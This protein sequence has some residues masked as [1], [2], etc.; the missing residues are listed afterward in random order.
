ADL[1]QFQLPSVLV[2]RT[3][4]LR[5]SPAESRPPSVYRLVRSGAYYDVWQR[6]EHFAPI[7][8]HLPLGSD[9]QPGAVPSCSQV[10]ALAR[11][12]PRG[13]L[14][15]VPRSRVVLP[16]W[17]RARYAGSWPTGAGSAEA[18][19]TTAARGRYEVWLQGSFH[20]ELTAQLDGRTTG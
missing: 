12:D 1:D 17:S 19:V 2:Y 7:R 8:A 9:V 5:R 20:G 3:L 18:R 4:V 10:V 15:T 6:P 13:R 14:V 11:H 16:D